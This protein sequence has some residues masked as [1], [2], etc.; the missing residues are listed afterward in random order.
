MFWHRFI[1]YTHS[2]NGSRGRIKSI[3]SLQDHIFIHMGAILLAYVFT[4]FCGRKFASVHN[5]ICTVFS[6]QY[7]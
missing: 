2:S 1:L 4:T 3:I 7:I 6:Y 5:D